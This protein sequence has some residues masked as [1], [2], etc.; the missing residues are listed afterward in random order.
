MKLSDPSVVFL[1][2]RSDVQDGNAYLIAVQAHLAAALER[3]DDS[4]ILVGR[5]SR[6]P[7]R[8]YEVIFFV[9]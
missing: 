1:A 4:I 2:S 6:T 3:H 7:Y 5:V 8:R 9:M